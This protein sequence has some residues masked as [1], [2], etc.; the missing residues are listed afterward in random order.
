MKVIQEADRLDARLPLAILLIT[1]GS[2]IVGLLAAL[3]VQRAS[4][5]PL[6]RGASARGS[7]PAFQGDAVAGQPAGLFA[8]HAGAAPTR[9]LPPELSQYGWVDRQ[10]G[11][12]RI[13]LERA[14]ELYMQRSSHA[15]PPR[16]SEGGLR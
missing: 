9:V 13:P 10:R 1:L 14:K 7:R 2:I 5:E 12:A 6:T 16:P 11:I 8:R 3:W 4:L 15:A